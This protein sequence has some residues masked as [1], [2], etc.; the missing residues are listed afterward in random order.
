M[1]LPSLT[2]W[3]IGCL[4]IPSLFAS[5]TL[6]PPAPFAG[7][8]SAFAAPFV[9]VAGIAVPED[10]GVG[11]VGDEAFCD[12]AAFVAVVPGFSFCAA[13]SFFHFFTVSFARSATFLSS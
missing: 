2:L 4:L 6:F 9:V 10:A 1:I 7:I 12:G 3:S 8:L 11:I 13:T 5:R